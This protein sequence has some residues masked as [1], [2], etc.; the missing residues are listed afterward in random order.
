MRNIFRE[1]DNQHARAV[2]FMIVATFLFAVMNILV[3]TVSNIPSYEAVLFR[4]VVMLLVTGYMLKRANL[5]P[6]TKKHIWILLGRGV[7]GSISLLVF[8]YTLQHL[9]LATSVTIA[10]LS[11]VFTII[12]AS[13][14]LREHMHWKQW[15]FFIIS[16]SGIFMING[17]EKTED[18]RLMLI[19]I[20]GAAF[21]GLAYNAL[22]KTANVVPAL[23]VVF[24]LPLTTIPIVAPFCITHWVMPQGIEWVWL[25]CVGLVTQVAQIYMTRA[26]QMEKAGS[27][28][29]YSYLGVV[30]AL[31]FGYL[32][33]N[34]RFHIIAITG[35]CTVIF[36]ILLNFFYVNRVTSAKRFRAYFR[37]FPGF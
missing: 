37:G 3:K 28:A 5:N 1:P 27:I 19:G 31:L 34:E 17:F 2:Y 6:F 4:S 11:P 22:R 15:V 32:F 18:T 21:S 9:H 26:Y 20:V 25:I 7:A 8:F 23:V 30:F 24:Y 36:G 29:N 16:F 12:F 10:Y 35:M 14:L 13:V 33:F